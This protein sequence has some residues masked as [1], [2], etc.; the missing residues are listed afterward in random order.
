M[1]TIAALDPPVNT[2]RSL[3]RLLAYL[4]DAG[5]AFVTPTPATHRRV[6]ARPG[7]ARA[8]DLRDIFGWSLPFHPG[9]LPGDLFRDL[10]EDGVLEPAA[11]GWRARV[12]ASSLGDDLFLHAAFPPIQDDA[13]F[14]GPDTYRFARF[15]ESE[16]DDRPIDLAVEVGVGSGAGAVAVARRFAPRRL[17]ATDVNPAALGLAAVNLA[18]A[19]VEAE[20]RLADGLMGL[21][22]PADLIVANPPF[23]AGDG[24]RTY[25]DGGDMHGARVSLDWTLEGS[26]RLAAGG[27]MLL[28]TGSAIVGGRDPLRDALMAQLDAARFEV[29]YAEID[30]DIFGS[31]LA[32]KA[33]Q[34]V[35]RIAAVGVIVSRRA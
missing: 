2:T 19:K 7:R 23:I 24:G 34:D 33:Y 6:I 21:D 4:R 26:R 28:Y 35:E 12:R 5:Y 14:F 29:R 27:R 31:Q 17:I 13:V 22:G 8:R 32:S 30:P 15:L 10:T 16:A 1:I 3:A 25:R 18:G 20:L 9:L 11:E